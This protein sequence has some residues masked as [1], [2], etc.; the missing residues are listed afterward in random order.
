MRY[1]HDTH[2]FIWLNG[3]PSKLSERAAALCS[4]P[5]NVLQLS[6]ASIWEMQIKL[7]LGKL[8]LPAS[9]AEIVA[10]QQNT[11]GIQLLPIDLPHIL[12]LAVLSHQHRDPFD[13]LLIAQARVEGL[14]I[15]SNDQQILKYSI[16]VI[17]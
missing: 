5:S 15:I 4:D 10:V 13:R 9:L 12:E 16:P 3:T 2:A 17:W 7:G 1:L 11:N 8:K 14:Q 6:L